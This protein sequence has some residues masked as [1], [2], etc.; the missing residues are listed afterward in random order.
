[1]K[2]DWRGWIGKLA[3][4]RGTTKKL[5]TLIKK[6]ILIVILNRNHLVL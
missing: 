5:Q 6:L 4:P 1:M 2:K 3:H